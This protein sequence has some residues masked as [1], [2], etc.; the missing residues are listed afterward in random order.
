MKTPIAFLISALIAYMLGA[1]TSSWIIASNV[2]E[3]GLEVTFADRVAWI[4]HDQVSMLPIYLPVVIV[5][6]LVAYA[7]TA[8]VLKWVPNLR[9]L[10]FV[11]AGAAAM[12]ASNQ[13][14]LLATDLHGLPATR[15]FAGL[16]LQMLAGAV[17]GFAYVKLG[18]RS[19]EL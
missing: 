6:L 14:I 10:G 18:P 13:L 2:A 19:A 4:A 5:G 7:V 15:S 8:Q 9:L 3:L 12:Y 11:L 1:A 16:S 17:A